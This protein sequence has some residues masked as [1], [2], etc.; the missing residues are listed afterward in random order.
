MGLG[1]RQNSYWISLSVMLTNVQTHTHIQTRRYGH[2]DAQTYRQFVSSWVFT[3][4][5]PHNVTSKR[6][7]KYKLV[8]ANLNQKSLNY[9]S[10]AGS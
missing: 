1:S 10:K 3:A 9:K 7:T 4:C 5:E 6:I 8:Y 2:T